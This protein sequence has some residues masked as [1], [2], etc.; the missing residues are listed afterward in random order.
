VSEV[1]VVTG[2]S[3]GVGR[4]VAREFGRHGASV[5]LLARG[6][7]GLDGAK[8]EIENEGGRALVLPTDVSNPDQ[9]ETAAQ[10]TE[11]AFGPIDIW[12]NDAMTTVFA[13]FAEVEPDEF[14]RATEVTYLG[15]VWGTRSAL[16]R[17]LPR[18]RGTIVQVGSALAYRGIP[19]QS[20]YCGAKHAMK[21]FFESVR[22]ELRHTKS[23]VH[24][25]M[26]HLPG[27]NTPQFDHCLAKTPNQP[28]PV[29]PIYQPEVAAKAVHW[30]AHA[31]RREHYVGVPTIYTIWGNK[32]APWF[33]E[34]YLARTGFDSQQV[35]DEPLDP[36]RRAN[37]FE[38]VPGD[39]G[40]H[41]RFDDK[42]HDTS[43]QTWL[44]EH[45]GAAAVGVLAGAGALLTGL[46]RR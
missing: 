36:D 5:A 46:L 9:V 37:L 12:V 15:A 33:A 45:R 35:P 3:S 29:P 1:V 18:D 28:M 24:M 23:N 19:L 4:A 43:L 10:S 32:L 6:R 13:P 20:A 17:M 38:P 21:G 27:L 30:A 44:A 2:A 34:W 22:C 41:G 26:V 7:D 31:R 8:R 14:R 16:R 25:T 40:A 11:E 42:A 39:A